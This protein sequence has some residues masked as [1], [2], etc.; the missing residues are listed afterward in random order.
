[1]LSACAGGEFGEHTEGAGGKRL[2]HAAFL[3]LLAE[4]VNG[5]ALYFR[6]ALYCCISTIQHY[7]NSIT[8]DCT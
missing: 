3:S 8:S 2:L 1:M 4:P 7:C 6:G 5:T